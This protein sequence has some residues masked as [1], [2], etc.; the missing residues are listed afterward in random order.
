MSNL[1]ATNRTLKIS[2]LASGSGE[3]CHVFVSL[4]TDA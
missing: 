4:L 2:E 3:F 1:D